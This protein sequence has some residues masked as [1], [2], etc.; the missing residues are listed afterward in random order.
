[1]GQQNLK[2]FITEYYKKLFGAHE[3]NFFNLREEVNH[4][5]TQ[6][7]Q[8]EN[9]IL[10]AP[11]TEEEVYE[12]ISNMEHNKAPGPHGFP[13]KFY[14]TFWQVIKFDR[15]AMFTQLQDGDIPL[16]KLNFG[17]VTLLPKK[18]DASRI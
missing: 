15:M 11:F 8:E 3:A 2:V 18:E 12:A 13:T 14:Q 17:L 9:N 10:T 4:D 16:Y 1:V 6:L 7:S 5:I